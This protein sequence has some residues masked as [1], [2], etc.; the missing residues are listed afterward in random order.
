MKVQAIFTYQADIKRVRL[1]RIIY[2]NGYKRLS[3]SLEPCLYYRRNEGDGHEAL[4]VLCV[5]IHWARSVS[6][7]WA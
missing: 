4:G 5:R 6:G 7:R 2:G 3:F 1:F